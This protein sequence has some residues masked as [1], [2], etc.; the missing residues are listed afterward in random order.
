MKKMLLFKKVCFALLA[1][2]IFFSGCSKKNEEP[3]PSD[4]RSPYFAK[5]ISDWSIAFSD[6]QIYV[7]TVG[8]GWYKV[9]PITWTAVTNTNSETKND[10][11]SGYKV[12]GF[13]SEEDNDN[14][15][16][17][18]HPFSMPG[19]EWAYFIHKNGNSII[20]QGD[21]NSWWE[22]PF[23]KDISGI[24]KAGTGLLDGVEMK[25]SAKRR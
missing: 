4:P 20:E 1:A 15:W 19:D 2:G 11:P 13:V 18:G 23:A 25:G 16:N 8:G 24:A 17:V 10:Y 5:W 9:S 6:N 22:G 7:E 21:D 14:G 3:E 12:T